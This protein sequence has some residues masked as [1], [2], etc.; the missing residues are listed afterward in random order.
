LVDQPGQNFNR[1]GGLS[2]QIYQGLMARGFNAAQAAALT[3]NMQQES[4]FSTGALNP[5][6]GAF[7]L[8][9]WRNERRDNLNAFAAAQGKSPTDLGTQLDFVKHEMGTTEAGNSRA[10]LAATDVASANHALHQYIRYGDNTEG[11]R[12]ANAQ[13]VAGGKFPAGGSVGSG[14]GVAAAAPGAPA[15][16]V[17]TAAPPSMGSMIGQ[18]LGS[19]ASPGGGGGGMNNAALAQAA[20]PA[21]GP[22][23]AFRAAADDA[24]QASNLTA[25]GPPGAGAAAQ[26]GAGP[27]G[28]TGLL[29]LMQDP[30]A[31]T[32]LQLPTD[33]P[34]VGM[35]GLLYGGG[36][37]LGVRHPAVTRLT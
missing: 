25:G 9:Q 33:T 4:N 31:Q 27:G 22:Q 24:A 28:M 14:S 21:P 18:A 34:M 17:Q 26:P 8:I 20:P 5:G 36:A 23:M 32:Q 16:T 19:M 12:L 3:G 35:S 6:E 10:F 1:P 15:Q 29:G 30:T 13:A 37:G 2:A 7:G 11:T